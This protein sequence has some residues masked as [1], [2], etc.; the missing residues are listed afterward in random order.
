MAALD[1]ADVV[2]E[3]E[4]G[5]DVGFDGELEGLLG[6]RGHGEEFVFEGDELLMKVDARHGLLLGRG[7]WGMP[8][9]P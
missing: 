4:V 9:S 5:G 6:E 2:D 1:L 7:N 8:P 3:G